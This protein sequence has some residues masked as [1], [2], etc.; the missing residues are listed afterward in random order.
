MEKDLEILDMP[1]KALIP[2]WETCVRSAMTAKVSV[3]D[4]ISTSINT[5]VR[6]S[7]NRAIYIR[8]TNRSML[9]RLSTE[10]I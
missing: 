3:E 6:H 4:D 2:A 9:E 7:R 5:N 8:L 1:V 10:N